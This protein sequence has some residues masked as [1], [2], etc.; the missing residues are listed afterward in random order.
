VYHNKIYHQRTFLP[1]PISKNH[2]LG[3]LVLMMLFIG[4]KTS[5]AQVSYLPYS[6]QFYQKLNKEAYSAPSNFHSSLKP[7]V[8]A[9]SGALQHRYDSLMTPNPND[10]TKG[11]IYQLWFERH[12]LQEKTKDYTIY[13]DILPDIQ[14]GTSLT[15]KCLLGSIPVG[16]NW[17]A[18]LAKTSF[19]TVAYTKTKQDLPTT[20]TII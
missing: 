7:Y 5:L 2:L 10:T 1:L 12:L 20:R 11:I 9:D 17:V 4:V 19:F 18:Q 8:I 6:Y 16:Y 14:G 13:F 15:K 3:C